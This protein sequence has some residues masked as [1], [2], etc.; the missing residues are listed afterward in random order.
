[1]SISKNTPSVFLSYSSLDKDLVKKIAN[2]LIKSGIRPWLDEIELRKSGGLNLK[3]EIKEAIQRKKKSCMVLFLSENSIKSAWVENEIKWIQ[4]KRKSGVR[5]IPIL[6]AKYEDL[7]LPNYLI[8]LLESED[9]E[10]TIYYL[11]HLEKEYDN[12]MTNL[13]MSV[14]NFFELDKASEL[15]FHAGHRLPLNTINIPDVWRDKFVL[16]FRTCLKD[17]SPNDTPSISEWKSISRGIH[18]TKLALSSLKIICFCGHTPIS[19]TGI[20]AKFWGRGSNSKLHCWNF[21]D[22]EVW[23]CDYTSKKYRA[24]QLKFDIVDSNDFKLKTSKNN[25]TF[26][27]GWQTNIFDDI[28][29]FFKNQTHIKWMKFQE[30]W[31][32]FKCLLINQLIF[33]I[34]E[35]SKDFREINLILGVPL[36]LAAILLWNIRSIKTI[37]LLEYK[38]IGKTKYIKVV[39]LQ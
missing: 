24:D 23:V 1:M 36:S 14:Y 4:K 12:L 39:Q 22:S 31:K 10:R 7:T 11:K 26:F 9:N 29:N 8:N 25:L 3:T 2:D 15:V 34:S 20:I 28:Q 33:Y 17:G 19:F 21:Q 38:R 27:V 37:N 32:E 5:I 6:L 35:N 18:R 16:D 30:D 13:V